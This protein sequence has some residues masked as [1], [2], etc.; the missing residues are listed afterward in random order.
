MPPLRGAGA[1]HSAPT[2][3]ADGRSGDRFACFLFFFSSFS[4]FSR[5]ESDRVVLERLIANGKPPQKVAA[6]ARI[7]LLS[8]RGVGT[9][10]IARGSRRSAG[11]MAGREIN[12][13][14]CGSC[15]WRRARAQSYGASCLSF[16]ALSRRS[17]ARALAAAAKSLTFSKYTPVSVISILMLSLL[18]NAARAAGNSPAATGRLPA[19]AHAF[20]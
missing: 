9:M 2:N 6:R 16:P 17:Q 7:V 4:E 8:G 14:P 3:V 10:A 5:F 20:E 18:H 1:S 15:R 11:R 13:P 12:L 19:A